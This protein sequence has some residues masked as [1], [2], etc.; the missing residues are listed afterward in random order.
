MSQRGIAAACVA[1]R[2]AMWEDMVDKDSLCRRVSPSA[3]IGSDIPR[4][5]VGVSDGRGGH[6]GVQADQATAALRL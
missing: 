2:D 1:E 4:S 3:E 5:P 6:G